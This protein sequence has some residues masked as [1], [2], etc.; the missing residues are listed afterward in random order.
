MT[1]Y[2]FRIVE[3]PNGVAF[4]F[5]QD[6]FEVGGGF[7]P[8][9]RNDSDMTS[10]WND[11]YEECDTWLGSLSGFGHDLTKIETHEYVPDAELAIAQPAE[12]VGQS[13]R[14]EA[15]G[16]RCQWVSPGL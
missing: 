8:S 4:Q 5:L 10:A 16:M 15:L 3:R 13:L 9:K 7:I 14:R 12:G 1:I 11:A 2:G 6:G